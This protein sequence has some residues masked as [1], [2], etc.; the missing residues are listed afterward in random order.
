[1][2][3][4][5]SLIGLFTLGFAEKS[6]IPASLDGSSRGKPYSADEIKRIKKIVR[7]RAGRGES[8]LPLFHSDAVNFK[9]AML[10]LKPT[11]VVADIGCGT[12]AAEVA[13]LKQ[14]A[15]F[16]RWYLVDIHGPSV[17]LARFILSSTAPKFAGRFKAKISKHSELGLPRESVDVMFMINVRLMAPRLVNDEQPR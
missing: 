13:A 6:P 10:G 3:F 14:G 9:V 4:L 5:G 11:D 7:D 16:S 15:Q 1:M 12:G 17:E 2:F 8:L